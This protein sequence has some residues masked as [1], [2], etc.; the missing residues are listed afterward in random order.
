MNEAAR[1]IDE[2]NAIAGEKLFGFCLDTGHLLLLSLDVYD[3]IVAL[4]DR[5]VA[6][7]IHDNNGVDDEHVLPYTGVLNWSRF[8]KG[9][10][11]I[12]YKGT[13]NFETCG[14]H[15]KFPKELLPSMLS[16]LADTGKYF[17]EK[18]NAPEEQ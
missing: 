8:I 4:G 5:I 6:L 15:R 2:L 11:E 3:C 9:L 1:Y 17:D 16:L 7:H 12:S 13:I 10:R 14:A 18:I